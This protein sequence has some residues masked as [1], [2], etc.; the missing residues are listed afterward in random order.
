[1]IED[2]QFLT[3]EIAPRL[4]RFHKKKRNVWNCRCPFCGDSQ[5]D[6]T[7]TRFYIYEKKG[8]LVCYCHNCHYAKPFNVFV[9]DFDSS[10]YSKYLLEKFGASSRNKKEISLENNSSVSEKLEK[11]SERRKSNEFYLNKLHGPLSELSSNHDV[12]KIAKERKIPTKYWSKLYYTPNYKK[13]INKIA[14]ETFNSEYDGK[15]GRL[16]IPFFDEEG[17]IQAFQ[18]RS[19]EPNSKVKYLTH[20]ISEDYSKIYGMDE[21]D[22]ESRVYVVEGP[23]DSMFIDNSVA[24]AGA[25][26]KNVDFKDSVMIFDNEPRNKDIVKAVGR[27]IEDGYKVYIPPN[28]ISSKDINDMILDGY[29]K[30]KIKKIIDEN[31]FQGNKAKLKLTSWKRI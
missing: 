8:K 1:M 13:F 20:K 22:K 29:S 30:E 10:I 7:K 31:T 28:Y 17:Y 16:V 15:F 5:R 6:R 21:V 24:A 18:G 9:K 25:D 12:V 11:I 14:P 23:I 26:L 2:I 4:S 3:T 27:M 19:L